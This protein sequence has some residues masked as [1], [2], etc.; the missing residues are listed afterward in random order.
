MSFTSSESRW[1]DVYLAT[2]ARSVSTCG[3]FLA[4][5]A[6][7]LELQKHGGGGMSVAAIM[8]A[9]AVPPVVLA[10]WTGRLAD[11][12]DSRVLLVATGALQAVICVALAYT[13]GTTEIVALVGVLAV[14]L[15][16]TQ[17][18]L[19]A[20]IPA[21]VGAEDLPRAGAL[22]QTANSVGMLVA[23]ALG[24]LLT[25][26]FGLRVPLLIDAASYLALIGAAL[27]IRTRRGPATTAR[28]REAKTPWR[29][30]DDRVLWTT[31]VVFGAVLA[32]VSGVNVAGVFMVRGVL[33]SST[34]TYGLLEA[35]W[36][37]T[38][39]IGGWLLA[40]RRMDDAGL[41]VALLAALGFTSL[42]VLAV[43]AVPSVGWLVPVYAIGGLGNGVISVIPGI[44]Y[45]RRLPPQLRGRGFAVYGAVISGA[46]ALG[47]LLG[48]VLLAVAPVRTTIA[49]EA[50]FATLVTAAFAPLILRAATRERAAADK[51]ICLDKN[52]RRLHA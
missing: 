37:G 29:L 22:G 18:T 8:I 38:L 48:G 44:L 6:L 13:T 35:V 1:S 42:C 25:G 24:G 41:S 23:P 10:A 40:R 4:A 11:R 16:V 43:A 12:V 49:A 50:L 2:M 3:D 20:L 27:L 45:G 51:E 21:M 47:Y 30:F 36:S 34:T 7:V 32:S 17:P 14:G 39:M 52:N 33:H 28:R 19:S 46:G 5:T 31:T 9:A 15:A 26:Q